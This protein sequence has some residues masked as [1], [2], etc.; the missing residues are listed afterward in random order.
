MT[1]EFVRYRRLEHKLWWIRWKLAGAESPEEDLILDE[2]ESLWNALTDTERA[3]LP[4]EGPRCWP[5][6]NNA[7]S[8]QFAD[9]SLVSEPAAWAYEGF[10]SLQQTVLLEEAA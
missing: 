10:S 9:A 3:E 1:R 7:L 5:L 8:P 6:D 4:L 2:M